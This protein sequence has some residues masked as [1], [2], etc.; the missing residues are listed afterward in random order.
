M[1]TDPVSAL[2]T[3]E[4]VLLDLRPAQLASRALSL[5]IDITIQVFA[6]GVLFAVVGASGGSVDD[7]ALEAFALVATVGV[8][9]G[10]PT[11][12]ETLTRGRT[13][14]KLAMGL[15]VVRDDGG[16]ER[17]RQ[18]LVRALF[19]VVEIW[20][21]FGVLALFTSLF[22]SDGKRLGDI[23]G[24]TMV[25]RQ[26]IPRQDVYAPW[27]RPE[28]Q[29]WAANADL[30]RVP[31]DLALAARG[32][33]ARWAGIEDGA[34]RAAATDL[35]TRIA[36]YVSPSSPPGTSP[37]DYL[38]AVLM[39][40]RRRSTMRLSAAAPTAPPLAPMPTYPPPPAPPTAPTPNMPPPEATGAPGGF[41]TPG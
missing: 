16:P 2:V 40:R 7:A 28:L 22:S 4:A 39:E 41:I 20:L 36:R 6:L 10:Y 35:A 29:A 19:A 38:A 26:R 11:V 9:V 5:L 3:G 18:A 34:R 13:I 25:V 17:F 37:Q 33:I 30:S 32:L 8:I 31:D 27:L 24:G 23:F 1:Q 15:R 12:C 21:T 14:G